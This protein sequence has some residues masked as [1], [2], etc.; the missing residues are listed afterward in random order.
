MNL[1][2]I[3]IGAVDVNAATEFYKNLGLKLIVNALP[4][5]VRFECP[6]GDC[7]FSI[8][9]TEKVNSATTTI[10]FEVENLIE[11]VTEFK[12]KGIIFKTDPQEQSWL[13]H[14]A[15]LEDPEGNKIIIYHAGENRKNP[16]W[17]V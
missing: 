17:R 1:N 2:Q 12:T 4:N 8:H 6:E 7:T 14:E 13:W 15:N 16:P 3:T 11:K 5:Y 10:Y 9:K